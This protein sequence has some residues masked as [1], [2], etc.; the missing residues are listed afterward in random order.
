MCSPNKVGVKYARLPSGAKRLVSDVE[1]NVD[2]RV[3][4]GADDGV[5]GRRHSFTPPDAN[6][7]LPSGVMVITHG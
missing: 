6:T 1:P 7:A 2:D 5:A 3:A 4:G